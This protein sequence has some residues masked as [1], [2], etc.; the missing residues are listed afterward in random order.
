MEVG[1]R[2]SPDWHIGTISATKSATAGEKCAA[3]KESGQFATVEGC[4]RRSGANA[5]LPF[6]KR[7]TDGWRGGPG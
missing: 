4:Q 2:A 7:Y 5:L 3:C 1:G 6:A